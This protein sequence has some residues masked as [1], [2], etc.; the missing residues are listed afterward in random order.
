MRLIA[1]QSAGSGGDDVASRRETM[2]FYYAPGTCSLATQ[3]VLQEVGAEYEP[4]RVDFSTS[5]QRSPAFVAI[6]PKA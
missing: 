4:V 6:N 5:E 3:I 1:G 2:K